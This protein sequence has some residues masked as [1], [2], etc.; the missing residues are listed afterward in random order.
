MMAGNRKPK[1]KYD[2][3]RALSMALRVEDRFRTRQPLDESQTR[4]MGIAYHVAFDLMRSGRGDEESWSTLACMTNI[5]VVMA[6]QGIGGEHMAALARALD[7]IRRAKDRGRATGR[8]AFDGDALAAMVD[9]LAIHD[10]QLEA[11][12]IGDTRAALAEV[13]RRI[14]RKLGETPAAEPQRLAA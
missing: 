13:E 11:A 12:T 9:A 3:R 8:W 6:E 1:R 7:G 4:D 2:P 5:A 14:G 10:A